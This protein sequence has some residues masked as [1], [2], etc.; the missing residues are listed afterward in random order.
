MVVD[1]GAYGVFLEFA[2]VH[3]TPNSRAKPLT[4]FMPVGKRIL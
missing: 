2:H 1:C 4:G 3:V